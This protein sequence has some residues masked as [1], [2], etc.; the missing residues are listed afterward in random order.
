[1]GGGGGGRAGMRVGGDS[2]AWLGPDSGQGQ[3]EC[4]TYPWQPTR[5]GPA[6]PAASTP[7]A[8]PY[9]NPAHSFPGPQKCQSAVAPDAAAAAAI[10]GAPARLRRERGMRME[11]ERER[12]REGEGEGEGEGEPQPRE[13]GSWRGSGVTPAR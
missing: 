13:R 1:M 9:L 12:E 10:V 11:G 8:N 7:H 4:V 3:G 2:R 6:G 5:L